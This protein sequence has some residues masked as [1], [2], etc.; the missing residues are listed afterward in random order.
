LLFNGPAQ[1]AVGVQKGLDMKIAFLSALAAATLFAAPSFAYES[2]IE[3]LSVSGKVLVQTSKGFVQGVAGQPIADGSRV[4]VGDDS[5]AVVVSGLA[6]CQVQLPQGKVTIIN[7][8]TMCN[9]AAITPVHSREPLPPP[10]D[11][12]AVLLGVGFFGAVL[13]TGIIVTATNNNSPTLS[14]P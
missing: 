10:V 4:M 7:A 9:P 14:T 5:S 1:T 8:E 11:G 6:G 13:T 2:D 12:T 3:L